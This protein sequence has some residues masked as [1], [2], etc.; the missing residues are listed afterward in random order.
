MCDRE[1]G[2]ESGVSGERDVCLARPPLG[3][4]M[5]DCMETF[6][7]AALATTQQRPGQDVERFSS[8]DNEGAWA[9]RMRLVSVHN[10][11]HTW[12]ARMCPT[13]R[14]PLLTV[15]ANERSAVH[16]DNSLEDISSALA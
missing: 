9:L 4:W 13:R 3:L 1:R 2:D 12:R 15:C 11:D 10:H 5:N 14:L 16:M 8:G 7:V 6:E